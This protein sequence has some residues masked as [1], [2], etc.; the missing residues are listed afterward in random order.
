MLEKG[1]GDDSILIPCNREN[2]LISVDS[3]VEGVHFKWDW[4]HEKKVGRKALVASCSDILAMGGCATHFL[5]SLVIPPDLENTQLFNFLTGI[6]EFTEEYSLKLAGGNIT[7]GKLFE[8]HITVLGFK[9]G[10]RVITRAGAK[11]GD[12]I[13]LTG[14]LGGSQAGQMLLENNYNSLPEET[15]RRLVDRFLNPIFRLRE[16]RFIAQ[17]NG[18]SSMI[19]ISD[20]LYADLG[21]IIE[22]SSVGAKLELDSIPIY[23]GVAEF[24]H[25]AQLNPLELACKS[26]EEYELLFT[27]NQVEFRSLLTQAKTE[28]LKFTPIGQ[29]V[30]GNNISPLLPKNQGGYTHF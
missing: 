4:K 10:S 26:G 29:I 17:F 24:C 8:V 22:M 14:K 11:P 19:D 6:K 30:Q 13:L 28:G 7:G 20:G 9:Y 15:K 1:I 3:F 2:L 21:H 23:Q 25:H 27:I 5:L 18:V 12:I 16:A